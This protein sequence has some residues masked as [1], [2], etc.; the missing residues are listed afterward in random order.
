LRSRGLEWTDVR[1]LA[2]RSNEQLLESI[3]M[4]WLEERE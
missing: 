2:V 4:A 3:W 1:E